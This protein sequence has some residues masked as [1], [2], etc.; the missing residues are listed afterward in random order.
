MY[1]VTFGTLKVIMAE[2]GGFE[3]PEAFTSSL[4]E[5]DT[6]DHSDNSPYFYI[7]RLNVFFFYFSL[8]SI[9]YL[10]FYNLYITYAKKYLFLTINI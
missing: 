6:F 7:S 3:P 4:F 8:L 2:S 5:S 1:H 10:Y 9:Y